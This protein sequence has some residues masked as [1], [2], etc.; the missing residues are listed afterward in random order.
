MRGRPR[1]LSRQEAVELRRYREAGVSVRH[2]AA[3]YEVSEATVMRA[4]AELRQVMG[5][6]KIPNRRR[7][8]WHLIAR[9]LSAMQTQGH[10]NNAS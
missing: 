1:S 3:M 5:P 6:E 10:G 4:L 8:R 9:N 2:C 7:A